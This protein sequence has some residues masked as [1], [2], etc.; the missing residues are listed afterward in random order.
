M[1]VFHHLLHT[2][3]KE[4][5]L[6]WHR[7]FSVS[8]QCVVFLW[9]EF[10]WRQKESPVVRCK[11]S[12]DV[13]IT[14]KRHYFIEPLLI[15]SVCCIRDHICDGFCPDHSFLSRWTTA[16]VIFLSGRE[17][18][19]ALKCQIETSTTSILAPNITRKYVKLLV[20]PNLRYFWIGRLQ[21]LLCFPSS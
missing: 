7:P 1:Y 13:H 4:W 17:S 8:K 20:L 18:R 16:V 21:F 5:L 2:V 6:T 14:S 12:S 10:S 19:Y 11:K 9:A 15:R 3:L